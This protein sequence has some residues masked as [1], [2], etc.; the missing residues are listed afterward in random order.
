[1]NQCFGRFRCVNGHDLCATMLPGSDCP[2]CAPIECGH[3]YRYYPQEQ[4]HQCRWCG[5]PRPDDWCDP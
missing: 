3:D 5:E 1:M 4:Q 2:Y